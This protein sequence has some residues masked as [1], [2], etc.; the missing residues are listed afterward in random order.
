M[1]EDTG[2]AHMIKARDIMTKDVITVYPDT[3]HMA[4]AIQ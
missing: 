2:G 3:G 1:L 4:D